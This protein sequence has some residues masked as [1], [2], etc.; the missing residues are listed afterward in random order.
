[1]HRAPPSVPVRRVAIELLGG[2]AGQ[3]PN[4]LNEQVFQAVLDLATGSPL[5]TTVDLGILQDATTHPAFTALL[6]RAAASIAGRAD[7]TVVVWVSASGLRELPALPADVAV[8]FGLLPGSP[9]GTLD[10]LTEHCAGALRADDRNVAQIPLA[11]RPDTMRE[12]HVPPIGGC[13]ILEQGALFFGADG[14]A[15][16]CQRH[17]AAGVPLTDR[18]DAAMPEGLG[19]LARLRHFL[20]LDRRAEASP[21]CASCPLGISSVLGDGLRDYWTSRDDA[22][23]VAALDERVHLFRDVAPTP[24][25]AVRVDLGCGPAK[26]PGF[27]GVD[28]FPL[29]GVDVVCDLDKSLPF[30]DDSVDYIMA[31]HSLEH[32]AD[33]S[34]TIEEVFR[35][36]RDRAIVTIISPYHATG[37]NR[38]NPYHKQ[39]FN[40]HTARFFTD[41]IIGTACPRRRLSF[42][43]CRPL[44]P[45]E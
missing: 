13:P 9:A 35:V 25:R 8:A 36:C 1:M 37:L 39:A 3:P 38:A 14:A 2:S 17:A 10:V 41:K 29:P 6:S 34:A 30:A 40:E 20:R 33:L 21:V 11:V 26:T 43:P 42:P 16:A 4:V 12:P 28:R 31:S 32:I 27:V 19:E 18:I 15:F 22:E 24:H 44:G 23:P 45:R 7:A 5:V